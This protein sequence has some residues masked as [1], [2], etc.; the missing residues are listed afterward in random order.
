MHS[1]F[2]RIWYK[3]DR[4]FVCPRPPR[5]FPVLG[6]ALL[7]ALLLTA[8]SA[9]QPASVASAGELYVTLLHTSDEHSALLPEPLVEYRPDGPAPARGGIARL[10][11]VVERVRAHKAAAGEPVLLT[12]AG[13]Y[14][15]GS[16]FAWLALEGEAPEL[17]LMVELGYD[18]VTLGNHEF[19]FGSDRLA[20]Y[21]AAA[22]YPDAARRTALVAANTRPPPGHPLAE[23]GIER[24]RLIELPNGLKVGFF[25]LLGRGAARFVTMAA[26]VEFADA[27]AAAATAVEELRGAG[28]HVVVALTHSGV[29]EDRALA[30]AVPGI[31]VILG[32]HDHRLFDEPLVEAGTPIVHPGAHLGQVVQLELGYDPQTGAVRVRNPQ[33]GTPYLQPL[34]STVEETAWMAERVE[35]YRQQ[36]DRRFA[37]MTDGRV[38]AVDQTVVRSSFTLPARPPYT[39]TGLGNFV[40]DALRQAAEGAT[41]ERVDFAFQANG[42]IRG[43]LVPG[44]SA[45]NQGE[46]VAYDL[47][48]VVGMGT[49]PDGRPGFPLVSVRLTGEEVRRVLEISTLLSGMLRN[50][51]FLQ[52][53]GLRARY[54]PAR[55][56]WMRIP[57]RGTPIPSGR[58]VLSAHRVA[59]DTL[60]PLE[61]GDTTLYH[62]VTDYYVASF[63]PMI[64]EVVPSFALVPKDRSG[65]PIDDIDRAIVRRDGQE[66]KVWQAVFEFAAA[67]PPGP[68][69]NARV[70]EYYAAGVGR[71]ERARGTPLWLWPVVGLLLLL[72]L[73]VALFRRR[74]SRRAA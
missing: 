31:D 22:G 55:A 8:G 45:W 53:S 43:D 12:S 28:A 40:T 11:T 42:V 7:A 64:G 69:G 58:A 4:R 23:R 1:L 56:V 51:Y 63:L 73:L 47:A 33:T 72:A 44:G 10:A 37:E 3:P 5:R 24:T 59:G 25:G 26:P 29:A 18:I 67:Q 17:G 52:V 46:I 30:R 57:V 48:R 13:D 16:P 36:L 54:D 39:E 19:D 70:P 60:L 66:L 41:G 74:R 61:R 20:Q 49:G 62:V 6:G 34:D 21:L 2:T 27:R 15:T 68:D 14:L 71:L 50:S 35:A 9:A 65:V 32:G 38:N